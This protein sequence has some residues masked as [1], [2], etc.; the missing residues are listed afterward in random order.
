MKKSNDIKVV[1]LFAGVGGFRVGLEQ[2]ST[3]F[4]TVYANQWEPGKKSDYQYAYKCY[5]SHFGISDNYTNIDIGI[6]K[7]SIPKHDL[8]VGGFPCQDYSVAH[9]NSAKG[10]EGKK[11]VLWWEIRDIVSN[12]KPSFILLENVDR[13][14]KSPSKQ[15]G[16][17]FGIMLRTL[18][19]EGYNVEWRI[20]NAA[21]YGE[22]QRRRRVFIF[23]YKTD[24][25]GLFNDY[26]DCSLLLKNGFFSDIFPVDSTYS[27]IKDVKIGNNEFKDLVEVSDNFTF[28][29][30]NSGI[31]RSG[32]IVTIDTKPIKTQS[33]TL[34]DILEK[35]GVDDKYFI[36][37][38]LD[39]FHEL[40]DTKRIPRFTPD[41]EIYYYTE[42]KMKLPDPMDRPARTILTSEAKIARTTHVVVDPLTNRM[43][44][45]TPLECERLNG[46]KDNW[47]LT[48]MPES[49][50]Y[51]CMGNALVVPLVTKMGKKIIEM[52]DK[53]DE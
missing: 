15:R 29:F 46:F 42:G 52:V 47:T 10:I 19:D 30:L 41:L 32:R 20:I 4:K 22:V 37:K 51:F 11:G 16:R 18:H 44:L 7:D 33:M 36:L 26:D 50:R 31:M 5:T 35:N 40:K 28:E 34:Y 48:G 23:A 12:K 9:G 8:L 27:K 45:L 2:A 53:K 43:R 13:L 25:L 21:D 49:Y 24:I 3:R 6:V 1:E 38:D 39:K 17:D 14:I